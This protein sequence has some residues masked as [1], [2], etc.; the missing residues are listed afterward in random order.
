[1]SEN[2]DLV[3]SIV[4]KHERGDFSS[5]DWADSDIEYAIVGAPDSGVWKGRAAMSKAWGEVLAAYTDNSV[6]VEEIRQIADE[7]VL[8]LSAF[9]GRGKAAGSAL[10][11]AYERVPR[12]S[13]K[14]ATAGLFGTSSTSTVTEPSPISA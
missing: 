13:G 10:P 2:L 11:T 1:M 12:P 9:A 4:A 7:R 14:S 3:R 8:V 6:V 5:A